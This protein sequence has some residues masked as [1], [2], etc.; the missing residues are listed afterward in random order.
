MTRHQGRHFLH[1]PGPSPVP[2]RVLRAMDM[3]VIDHRSAEFGELGKAVLSGSQKIFR[4]A[5]PVIIYPSSGTGAWEA[6]IVNTLSPGDKVLM[7]ETGHFATLWRQMAARWGVEVDFIPGD[8][9]RGVD[10]AMIEEKLAADT[11]H[12]IKAVMVVHNETSTGAT[13]R[14]GEVRAAMD[15]AKHPALLMVDTISG[16]ASA[17]FRFDEWKVD[18]AVSCSQK[19]FML[20]PGLGFNAVSDRA[21]A[22][23]KTNKMPR[24]FWDWEDML[25]LNANGFFPYTPATNLLYG[26]REA[27]AMLLEEGL[28]EVFA[29]H[30]RLAEATRAAV[31]HW[32]LEVLCQEPRDYSPVLTAVL[33]PPGHDADQFRQVVL[34][35]YNMSL[36]SGLSKVAGKVFRI[37]HLGECNELTLMAA[38]SGVEM[39]LRVAGVPHRAGGVDAAMALLEQPMPGN[40]PRHLAVVN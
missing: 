9:R 25:K 27:I 13:S 17:D 32:G 29:R 3:P 10:P 30:Q 1:I 15:R 23:A 2:E 28:D 19:G 34:D 18:V 24:S 4:T 6:A 12:Q 8:W 20:P 5:S 11:A 26:L 21:R 14:I 7:V 31:Q 39:G 33:M 40:A 16:L 37:G 36:G 22:V 35:N 38:L